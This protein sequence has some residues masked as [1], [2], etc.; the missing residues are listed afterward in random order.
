MNDNMLQ[1]AFAIYNN[2]GVYA[3][4]LGSGV[5]RSAEIPTGWEI[6]ERLI[7]QIANSKGEEFEDAEIW[8]RQHFG[9][10]PTYGGILGHLANTRAERNA[11]L[12]GYFEPTDEERERGAKLP[13]PAHHAIASLVKD[14]YIKVIL[15]TNFDRLLEKSLEEVGIIPDVIST[16][17]IAKSATPLQHSNITIIKL[18]GDYRNPESLNTPEELETYSE[19]HNKLLDRILDEYGLIVCGWSA[20]WDTALREAIYRTISRRYTTYWAAYGEPTKDAQDLINHRRAQIIEISGADSFFVEIQANVDSI[21]RFNRS[22]PLST[23]VAVERVKKFIKDGNDIDLKDLIHSEI[24][25]AYEAFTGEDFGVNLRREVSLPISSFDD[26]ERSLSIHFEAVQRALQVFQTLC[27][28]GKT[29][30][31]RYITNAVNRW[32]EIPIE[33]NKFPEPQFPL[34]ILIY[35]SGMSA[36]QSD[37]LEFLPAILNEPIVKSYQPQDNRGFIEIV[38]RDVILRL[39]SNADGTRWNRDIHKILRPIFVQSIPSDE[40]YDVTFDLFSMIFALVYLHQSGDDGWMP[41]H[42]TL[43]TSRSWH[44]MKRFWA[45]E[46]KAENGLLSAGLFESNV[47]L[48]TALRTYQK[49]AELFTRN[50]IMAWDAFPDFASIY[51]KGKLL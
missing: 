17:H 28:Y 51:Q 40:K 12:K 16:K 37:N 50:K 25:Q 42:I 48:H 19:S 15:T 43:Y 18:H 46:R 4:L 30:H 10:E 26:Y 13:T 29:H 47:D 9:T 22:N 36:L 8:Y 39:I 21:A 35:V 11:A 32:G 7:H 45:R 3:L 31:A 1:L 20:E 41:A 44:E 6:I 33:Q 49:I 24:E 23:A 14:G 5:S 2:P 27:W 34:L 38:S